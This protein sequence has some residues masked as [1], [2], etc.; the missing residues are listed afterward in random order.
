M[1]PSGCKIVEKLSDRKETLSTRDKVTLLN[2]SSKIPLPCFALWISWK[3]P[4][5]PPLIH[6]IGK[7]NE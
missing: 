4:L 5:K 3:A 6:G 2:R 7:L 1:G